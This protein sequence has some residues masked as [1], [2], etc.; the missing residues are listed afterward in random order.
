MIY[1]KPRRYEVTDPRGELHKRKSA[2][3]YT[4]LVVARRESDGK[5]ARAFC[6]SESLANKQA[7]QWRKYGYAVVV[8][9]IP[10]AATIL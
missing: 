1:P 4:H 3:V 5:A 7:A 2:R 10:P 9:V 8:V 6:G